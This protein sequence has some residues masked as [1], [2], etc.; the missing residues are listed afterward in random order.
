LKDKVLALEY[1]Y[2]STVNSTSALNIAVAD[3]HNAS[4]ALIFEKKVLVVEYRYRITVPS[5]SAIN[6]AVDDLHNASPALIF[7]KRYWL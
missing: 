2:S 5:N 7:E 3:L 4:P 6:T 1:S